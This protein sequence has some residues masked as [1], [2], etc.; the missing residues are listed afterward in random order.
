MGKMYQRG[1]ATPANRNLFAV[2]EDLPLLEN[3]QAESFHHIV[4]KLLYVAKRARIDL[5]LAIAFLCSRV[6]KSTQED[7]EKLQRVLKY[8]HNTIDLPRIIGVK[9]FKVLQTWV[10]ASYTPV[11]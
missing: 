8:I 5:Q 10:D 3:R 2:N 1:A 11:A 6:S 7:W 9:D 4:A